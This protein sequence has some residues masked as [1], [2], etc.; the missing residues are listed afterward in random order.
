[1]P[2]RPALDWLAVAR[3]DG[4][5]YAVEQS[6]HLSRLAPN[7]GLPFTVADAVPRCTVVLLKLARGM[8]EEELR[9]LAER[10]AVAW[11]QAASATWERVRART[12]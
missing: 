2:R 10:M 7:G 5:N 3:K 1:M 4:E 6:S 12:A 9:A 8:T 11:H